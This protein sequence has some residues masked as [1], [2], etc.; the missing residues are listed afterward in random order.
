MGWSINFHV[1]YAPSHQGHFLRGSRWDSQ[2]RV[3]HV[4]RS[5]YNLLVCG[6][7]AQ[8]RP[9]WRTSALIAQPVITRWRE[10]TSD[11]GK[12]RLA[13][14]FTMWEC[15]NKSSHLQLECSSLLDIGAFLTACLHALCNAKLFLFHSATCDYFPYWVSKDSQ[16]RPFPWKKCY[17][18]R[19]QITNWEIVLS[20][21]H[22]WIYFVLCGYNVFMTLS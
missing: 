4:V 19:I 18:P 17:P 22:P 3:G 10:L 5:K 1:I 12:R 11:H 21:V 15:Y 8:L 13:G 16:P 7:T 6:H 9:R 14:I 2:S 20:M